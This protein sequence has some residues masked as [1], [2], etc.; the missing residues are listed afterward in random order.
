MTKISLGIPEKGNF[1]CIRAEILLKVLISMRHQINLSYKMSHH[2]TISPSREHLRACSVIL[3]DHFVK[4]ISVTTALFYHTVI[5]NNF[6]VPVN[7]AIVHSQNTPLAQFVFLLSCEKHACFCE[8]QF[9]QISLNISPD[10]VLKLK[11][12]W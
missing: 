5:M 10:S 2:D 8:P 12:F 9:G 6:H 3:S 1:V 4:A 7:S 11:T